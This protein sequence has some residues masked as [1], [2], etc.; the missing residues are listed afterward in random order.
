VGEKAS[1]S[2]KLRRTALLLIAVS[3]VLIMFFGLLQRRLIYYPTRL[4]DPDARRW[5]M[6][7]DMAPWQTSDGR[8]IGWKRLSKSAPPV[9][10]ILIFHGNAGSALDR[11]HYAET[12]QSVEPFD[13]YILEYP[14]YGSRT[15][16]PSQQTILTAASE[17]LEATQTKLPLYAIGESLGTGVASFLA[18]SH[19]QRV[20]G[21]LLVAPY[22][23][24]VAVAQHHYPFLPAKWLL[25]DKYPSD[26]YLQTYPGPVAILLAGKDTV[27]PTPLGRKLFDEY[28]GRKKLWEFPDATHDGVTAIKPEAWREVLAFW[29][30]EEK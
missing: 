27:V 12:I 15:G 16:S 26:R 30:G 2:R 6:A 9:G 13:I 1:F 24:L 19:A 10:Q 29:R 23:N 8:S 5:A 17:A 11:T 18:G 28:R 21:L 20:N 25:R 4:P 22:N 7:V 14:G 3:L